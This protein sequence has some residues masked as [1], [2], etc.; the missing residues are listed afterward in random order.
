M[1]CSACGRQS[2]AN[3]KNCLYCGGQLVENKRSGPIHCCGC[4][5]AMN[6]VD[7]EGII[8]DVCP[9][10]N[11]MWFDTGELEEVL[12]KI[13]FSHEEGAGVRT[14]GSPVKNIPEAGPLRNCPHC[15]LVM[16]KKNYK[17]FS[18]IVIDVCRFHGL[19]LDA[20][21]LEKIRL[22]LDTGGAEK[23]RSMANMEEREAQ[24]AA[25]RAKKRSRL[26]DA[27]SSS[28]RVRYGKKNAETEVFFDFFELLTSYF[29]NFWT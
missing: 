18:G 23:E 19:Y 20:Q 14:K 13:E 11:G 5:N 10:C 26:H 7:I 17:R 22:F 28:V 21:E 15:N 4:T 8:I 2:T 29:H 12:E 1:K 25:I 16:G 9:T 6:E 24:K 27:R 3:R